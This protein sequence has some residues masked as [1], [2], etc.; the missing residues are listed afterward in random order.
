MLLIRRM[1]VDDL[2]TG[3]KSYP[4]KRFHINGTA[5][6][7]RQTSTALGW[8]KCRRSVCSGDGKKR[9]ANTFGMMADRVVSFTFCTCIL[10]QLVRKSTFRSPRNRISFG[11]RRP[12]EL[13]ERV[14]NRFASMGTPL[15][16]VAWGCSGRHRLRPPPATD[17]RYHHRRRWVGTVNR[18]ISQLNCVPRPDTHA[19]NDIIFT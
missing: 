18:T 7:R 15:D 3:T 2:C 13:T 16:V 17:R 1:T 6:V 5:I 4:I 11:D 8:V 12:R 14:G 10:Q 9:S 19:Q